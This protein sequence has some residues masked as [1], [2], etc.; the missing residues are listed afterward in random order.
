MARWWPGSCGPRGR[1]SGFKKGE[2]GYSFHQNLPLTNQQNQHNKHSPTNKTNIIGI[3]QPTKQ[4]RNCTLVLLLSFIL[5]NNHHRNLCSLSNIQANK[6]THQGCWG[7]G[8]V[9]EPGRR[10]SKFLKKRETVR[11]VQ[12]CVINAPS[13]FCRCP[14]HVPGQ[15][16]GLVWDFLFSSLFLV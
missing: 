4:K 3:N 14:C 9:G 11:Q 13:F 2:E 12:A 8:W 6:K 15:R 1:L 7:V 16:V 5:N 10:R